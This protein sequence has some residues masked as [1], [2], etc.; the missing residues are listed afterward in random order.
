M[1]F[2][3]KSSLPGAVNALLPG[4][5]TSINLANIETLRKQ[6]D[7][8]YFFGSALMAGSLLVLLLFND[9][10]MVGLAKMQLFAILIFLVFKYITTSGKR[11][12][13][14]CSGDDG[15]VRVLMRKKFASYQYMPSG[16]GDRGVYESSLSDAKGGNLGAIAIL[17]SVF[18]EGIGVPRN[19]GTSAQLS[20][21]YLRA[22][23]VREKGLCELQQTLDSFG[24]K[25]LEDFGF[26]SIEK[27]LFLDC[28]KDQGALSSLYGLS[29]SEARIAV[30]SSVLNKLVV[31][32]SRQL[33]ALKQTLRF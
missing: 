8:V 3:N 31:G 12:A 33:K 1:R 24:T 22:G 17:S 27:R 10:V 29:A 14:G 26:S 30:F 13:L 5:D 21:I 16:S 11:Q 23:G 32:E 28:Q 2:W 15:L 4:I 6:T 18:K 9:P 19:Y 25:N 20:D 7:N